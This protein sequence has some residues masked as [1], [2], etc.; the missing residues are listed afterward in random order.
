MSVLLSL[1]LDVLCY[2]FFPW[3]DRMNLETGSAATSGTSAYKNQ[4]EEMEDAVTSNPGTILV[5]LSSICRLNCAISN[6]VMKLWRLIFLQPST[7]LTPR[8]RRGRATEA[9]GEKKQEN[10]RWQDAS[11]DTGGGTGNSGRR[12]C[13]SDFRL[14]RHTVVECSAFLV[15]CIDSH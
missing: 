2:L 9:L 10:V 3:F 15:S 14:L 1:L 4:D 5:I 11:I 6:R 13:Q 12:R 7:S 8:R